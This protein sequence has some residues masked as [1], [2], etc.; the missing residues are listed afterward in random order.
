MALLGQG[1]LVI[2]HDVRD[3]SDY[4]E[5]HSKE[6]MLERVAVPGFRRGLRYVA[7]AGSPKYL[8]VYEVDDVATL[9]SRPYLDRLN[10]PT[11]WTRRALPNVYNNSRT[12]CRVVASRGGA[13]ICAFLLTVQLAPQAIGADTLRAWLSDEVLPQLAARPGIVGAHLLEG[14]QAASRTGTEEKRLRGVADAIADWIVLLG[15]Y[16]AP[17]LQ[18]SRDDALSDERLLAHG[19][20]AAPTVGLYQLLHA[21]TEPDLGAG[22]GGGL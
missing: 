18:A 1:A 8:N 11:P 5:W 2:W 12:L 7:L 21:I 3:E 13:G 16:D 6:H 19:A 20:A 10:D 4:N 9:T 17:A 15:G 14:D 22:V